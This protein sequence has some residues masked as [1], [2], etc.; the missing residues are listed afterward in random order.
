MVLG[1]R[2][3]T[4]TEALAGGMPVYKYFSNRFL[5]LLENTMTGQNLGEWHSGMRA[6][7]RKLLETV[8]WESF[9]DDFVFDTQMLVAAAHA[10]FRIGDVPAPPKYFEDASSISFKRSM[11]Y[12][13]SSLWILT[14]YMTHR[15]TCI[16]YAPLTTKCKK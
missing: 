6:Y 15:F 5:T 1:N 9:S 2:I 7:S 3:R 4:R 16:K 10:G 13:I 8:N 12:G 14:R 11:I